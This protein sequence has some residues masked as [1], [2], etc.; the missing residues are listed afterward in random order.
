MALGTGDGGKEQE[1]VAESPKSLLESRCLSGPVRRGVL[2]Y[3]SDRPGERNAAGTKPRHKGRSRATAARS[4]PALVTS[5]PPKAAPWWP[6][7]VCQGLEWQKGSA[8]VPE[9]KPGAHTTREGT[10]L[11]ITFFP[12]KAR[13]QKNKSLSIKFRRER[14]T[15]HGRSAPLC[16]GSGAPQCSSL[17]AL[18]PP[19]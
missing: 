12:P 4:S 16:R 5:C 10:L 11:K 1:E 7:R 2:S 19:S 6:G 13:W 14:V 15:T 3:R 17:G 18:P 8:A 9:E